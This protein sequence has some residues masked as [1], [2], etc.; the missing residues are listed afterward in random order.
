[1][2]VVEV[3]R[4]ALLGQKTSGV[5]S[6]KFLLDGKLIDSESVEYSSVLSRK[7]TMQ[8]NNQPTQFLEFDQTIKFQ[9]EAAPEVTKLR[10]LKG[11]GVFSDGELTLQSHTVTRL[12]P[13]LES[14]AQPP[15]TTPNPANLGVQPAK[16]K[17][18]GSIDLVWMLNLIS[19]VIFFRCSH[20]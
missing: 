11:V 5:A 19:L 12:D 1:L 9:S 2:D 10:L 6:A 15:A 7:G 8:Y 20:N 4:A 16:K 17:K 18:G 14:V 13:Y 3:S